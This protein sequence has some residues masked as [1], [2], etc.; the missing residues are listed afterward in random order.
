LGS[1][2]LPVDEA[3]FAGCKSRPPQVVEG[4]GLYD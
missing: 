4:G 3:L 2:I 1:A